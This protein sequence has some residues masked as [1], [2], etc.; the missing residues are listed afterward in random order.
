MWLDDHPVVVRAA[1]E[2]VEH[3]KSTSFHSQVKAN[4]VWSETYSF[5]CGKSVVPP[6]P[7]PF[8]VPSEAAPIHECLCTMATNI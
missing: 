4:I 5:P 1:Q 2:T 7:T 8:L 3:T 6:P